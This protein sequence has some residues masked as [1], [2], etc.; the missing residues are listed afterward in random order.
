MDDSY[1][2]TTK[3][4]G[5]VTAQNRFQKS[6]KKWR[7]SI[8]DMKGDHIPLSLNEPTLECGRCERRFYVSHSTCHR[9]GTHWHR[10]P[11]AECEMCG[12]LTQAVLASVLVLMA[13][14]VIAV[15]S[16]PDAHSMLYSL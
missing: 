13:E 1:I 7:Y 4:S 15:T 3:T 12:C 14:A 2:V 9:S 6:P 10:P 16:N 8:Y 5:T 11:V